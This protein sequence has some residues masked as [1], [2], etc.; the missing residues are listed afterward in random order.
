MKQQKKSALLNRP[1]TTPL[2]RPIK[3]WRHAWSK[4]RPARKGRR[5]SRPRRQNMKPRRRPSVPMRKRSGVHSQLELAGEP[6]P[7]NAPRLVAR[8]SRLRG[9]GALSNLADPQSAPR[10]VRH[11][12]ELL[13]AIRDRIAELNTTH[14][15]VESVSGAQL[16]YV[17]KCVGD[18]PPKRI[19][20][21]LA[22]LLLQTLGLEITLTPA[23]NFERFAYRLE[24]RKLVRKEARK[25]RGFAP[26]FPAASSKTRRTCPRTAIQSL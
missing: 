6:R 2:P 1:M 5:S 25:A 21:W 8:L 20:L 11:S 7:G 16:G 13:A 15:A 26:G 22:L 3:D 10:V 12:G 18:N 19:S 9:D 24:Q 4:S 17:S 14:A 23:P